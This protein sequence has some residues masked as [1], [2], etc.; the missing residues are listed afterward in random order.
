MTN[1]SEA[2]DRIAKLRDQ[3]NEHRYYLNVLDRST[4]SEAAA[5]SLKHELVQLESQFPELITA[6]S[7]TQR[8]AGKPLDKFLPIP[9]D[10]PMLSLNDVFDEAELAEWINRTKKLLGPDFNNEF[11][12]EIKMDGL[13]ASL[14]YEKGVLVQGLT[15]GDGRVGE[16]VTMNL[17]TVESI[18]LRLRQD[19]MVHPSVYNG[20]FEVRGEVLMYKNVFA[21]LNNQRLSKGLPLFANPRN[22]AAGT[23][24]QLDPALV[25][26]RNL[27]FHVYALITDVP[28]VSTH[29]AEHAL[30]H[31]LG[32]IVEPHSKVVHGLDKIMAFAGTWEN[33]RKELPYGTDGLV[34]TVNDRTSFGRLGV[35][36][37]APRGSVAYKF[38]AE[39]ATTTV[40]D[41]MV[42]IGRTGAATP[43]AVLEPTVV[44]GSTVG[45]ATL[46]NEGEVHRKDIRIGDTVIIQKAGDVIPEVVESLPKLRT[47]SEKVFQMPTHCPVCGTKF[48][49]GLKEAVWR[50]PNF[51]CPALERGRII[52]FA[53]KD[54]Y[55]IEGLGEKVVD[56]LLVAGLIEDA[57]DLFSL[58]VEQVADLD[59]F[60]QKSAENLVSSIQD[61][62]SVPFD[63]Y[64]YGLG[65]RHVGAQTASDLAEHFASLEQLKRST[66]DELQSVPGIGAVVAESVVQ[67]LAE[68]RNQALLSKLDASG[69]HP[70]AIKII[71]GK[72]T[73]QTFVITGTLETGSREVVEER[74]K[75]LGAK[76]GSAVTKDTDYLVVGEDPGKSKVE[77][78]TKLGT[79]Q[80]DE[81]ELRQLLD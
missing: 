8:V 62:K 1:K 75:A 33:K 32:F 13:A 6:D 58:K 48:V 40:K 57:A 44:A 30:A 54:A 31:R 70:Q 79:K 78:A 66:F 47:G 26:A 35:V 28:G 29:A 60:A 16:D 81:D 50:C 53:S 56:S 45:L 67:W 80:I 69:V 5:D 74:I 64:I 43:F 71:K 18:P 59:R 14:V 23:I 4:M 7:P 3:I 51:Y 49:K 17:R 37:K 12:A 39:Q 34:L 25:A 63:R 42:S 77:K 41:I 46:H 68:G 15:R 52:H 2:A 73:G 11:Y 9:H 19:S 65:I 76:A 55:D 72:L 38:A 10:S 22:T 24:R 20:R 36:G 21:E 27:A 61:R